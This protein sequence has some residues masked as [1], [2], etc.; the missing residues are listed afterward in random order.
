MLTSGIERNVFQ[1]VV[2]AFAISAAENFYGASVM[3][4][5]AVIKNI[6]E[7]LFA[8]PC[9]VPDDQTNQWQEKHQ[10]GPEYF[11]RCLCRTLKNCHDRIDVSDQYNKTE[12]SGKFHHNLLSDIY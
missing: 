10:Q 2:N 11:F 6:L 1:P 4:S 3:L 7:W 12:Y 5:E 9:E 8:R